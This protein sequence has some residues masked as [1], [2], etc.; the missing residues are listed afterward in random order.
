VSTDTTDVVHPD[1]PA[2]R[3][4]TRHARWASWVTFLL[5]FGVMAS[6][7]IDGV[8][9]VDIWGVDEATVTAES[10]SGATL[11]VRHPTVTRPAI[12]S[13]FE[14]VVERP[15]GFDGDVEIAVDLAYLEVWDLNGV[16]PSPADERSD[17]RRIIWTFDAPDGDVLD[18]SLDARIEPGVQAEKR[19]G[20]VSLLEAG[21]PEVTVR[22]DTKVRP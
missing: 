16:Y 14:I 19:A 11:S 5:L 1:S 22:F 12:A 3:A 17:G 8:D 15:D 20:A 10:D 4:V 18:I 7:V 9:L 21:E 6:A 2:G 13:P